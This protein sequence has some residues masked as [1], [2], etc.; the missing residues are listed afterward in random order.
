MIDFDKSKKSMYNWIKSVFDINRS[1]TGMGTFKTLL[2]IKDHLSGKFN[3]KY[4]KSGSKVF[5][6]TIPPEWNLNYGLMKDENDKILIHSKNSNLHIVGYSIPI[7]QWFS[8]EELEPHLFYLK[9]QK[10]TIPY[11]TSYYDKNWGICLSYNDFKKLDK[12][13][14]YY[15]EIDSSFNQKGKMYYGEW[16]K[17]GLIDEE[18]LISTYICHPSM[19]NNELSGPAV[20][21]ELI[22]WLDKIE[23]RFSYRVIF[24]P[25]TIGSIAYLA[26]NIKHFLNNVSSSLV[27]TCVGDNNKYSLLKTKYGDT[28]YDKLAELLIEK[29]SEDNYNTYSFLERGSD[30]RQYS[31]HPFNIPS[32]SLMRSKYGEYKEYHTSDDNLSFIS[33]NGLLGGLKLNYYYL[34][35]LDKNSKII[36]AVNC[37]P[38]LSKRNLYEKFSQKNTM[39]NSK[40]L[41][42]ILAY[43]DGTNNLIE[44]FVK[45][46]MSPEEFLQAFEI[47]K[48]EKLI[49]ISG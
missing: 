43:A 45:L 5:D 40:N 32:I 25:E 16:L 46:K 44:I 3:I 9:N 39:Y 24:I 14:K 19:A 28:I 10:N 13:V 42:N 22:K 26:N 21:M 1:L 27:I 6:W 49:K 11:V 18:I 7:K 34:L 12:R 48:K 35:F 41:T 47:L 15:V 37:E 4:F 20:T 17:K 2:T 31:S 23:T 38:M 33:E 36:S 30:E 29:I 8:F